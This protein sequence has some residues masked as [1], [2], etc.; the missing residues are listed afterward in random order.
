MEFLRINKI[1]PIMVLLSRSQHSGFVPPEHGELIESV[2]LSSLA[3]EMT[4]T[5]IELEKLRTTLGLVRPV[6]DYC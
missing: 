2:L 4:I 6:S 3:D 5:V 1:F